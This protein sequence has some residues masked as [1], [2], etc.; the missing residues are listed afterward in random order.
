MGNEYSLNRLFTKLVTIIIAIFTGIPENNAQ[1]FNSYHIKTTSTS[2]KNSNA[3]VVTCEAQF[4]HKPEV[5]WRLLNRFSE[6][7]SYI[8]RVSAVESLGVSNEKE[9]LFVMIDVPWPFSD[10]WN[11]LSITKEPIVNRLAWSMLEGNMK[12]NEGNLMVESKDQG[13]LVRMKVSVELDL[14]NW[15]VVWGT[16]RFLPKVMTAIGKQLAQGEKP[17]H[18]KT[19]EIKK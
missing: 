1:P 10:I 13:S 15:L 18:Q 5:V 6:F 2:S 17:I 11:V 16:K 7:S 14:P 19:E 9:K 4:P 12:K 8:P 3:K